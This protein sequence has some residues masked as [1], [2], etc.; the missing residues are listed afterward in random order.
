M[1]I[2]NRLSLLFTAL[3]ATILL[4][5]AA[6]IYFSAYQNR[7]TEFYNSLKKE[8]ITK[9]NLFFTAKVDAKTLQ[10]IY[11]SNREILNEVEVAIYDTSYTLLYH[12]ALDIDVVKETKSMLEQIKPG[13]QIQFYQ[14][15]WQVIGVVFPYENQKYIVVATAYDQHGYNKLHSLS[16]TILIIFIMSI[17]FI[18]V[19]G[20]FFS[21]R[22]FSPVSE[23]LSQV[24]NM[25]ASNLDLRLKSSGKDELA[26]LAD[27]FNEMLDRLEASFDTQK[28]FVSNISHEV[29]TPLS[30]IIA[31]LEL[32]TNKERSIEEYKIVITNTLDDAKKLAKLSNSL[33]DFAKANYDPVEISFKEIRLDEIIL[34]ARQQVQK[35][36]PKYHIDIHYVKE[37]END[38]DISIKGNEYLLKVAFANLIDNGCKFSND[39]TS[40][41]SIN[42]KNDKVIL[43]FA[44]NGIGIS[45]EDL[46]Q[47]FTPFY[48]GNNKKFAEG[49]GI[50]LS[51]SQ[52]IIH[53]HKGSISVVSGK[54]GTTFSIELPHI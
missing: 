39:H 22:A 6:L 45:E 4:V 48:R 17:V 47:I 11:K 46:K 21:T 9:A 10:T 43:K 41:V 14:D 15:K 32:S 26:E 33:L 16:R 30:A 3:T 50:G 27:T 53:I 34:D 7:E 25:T 2:K 24:K 29:R 13:K 42:L 44:D 31:E 37:I 18:Y 49:N 20:R 54:E 5:F 52:K 38:N 51:L 40:L 28:Q 8:A 12:D 23:I 36:N 1:K 19:A 35:Q